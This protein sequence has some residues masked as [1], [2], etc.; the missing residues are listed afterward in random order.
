MKS[1]S[2]VL[3]R[4]VDITTRDVIFRTIKKSNPEFSANAPK[5]KVGI[6]AP[7]RNGNPKIE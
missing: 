7:M 5:R 6:D 3:Y 2:T 4:V 1:I